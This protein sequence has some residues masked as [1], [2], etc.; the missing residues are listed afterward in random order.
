MRKQGRWLR[1]NDHI[2][3]V[4]QVQYIKLA[5]NEHWL[6]F[7]SGNFLKIGEQYI[8][9]LYEALGLPPRIPIQPST[10]QRFTAEPDP[11]RITGLY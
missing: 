10:E 4:D 2:V 8:D 11:E 3:N 9:P 5:G 6:Y 7:F 1:V